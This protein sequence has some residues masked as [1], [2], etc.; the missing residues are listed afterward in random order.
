MSTAVLVAA[1]HSLITLFRSLLP[2]WALWCLFCTEVTCVLT[3]EQHEIFCPLIPYRENLLPRADQQRALKQTRT[4]T[5]SENISPVSAAKTNTNM[6]MMRN[7]LTIFYIWNKRKQDHDQEI[8]HNMIAVRKYLII[9]YIQPTL[10]GRLDVK[11]ATK[12]RKTKQKKNKKRRRSKERRKKKRH[13][14][15]SK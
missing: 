11:K 7:Y 2:I 10:T 13:R 3:P 14:L 8:T 4:W 5:R 12:K 9:F 6:F 15:H 1:L